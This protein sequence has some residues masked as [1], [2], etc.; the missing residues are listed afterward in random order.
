MA[1]AGA[2]FTGVKATPWGGGDVR[3]LS[4]PSRASQVVFALT[5]LLVLLTLL[6]V[7]AW[8][9]VALLRL[10]TM[11]DGEP[12]TSDALDQRMR[13]LTSGLLSGAIICITYA[14]YEMNWQETCP[15]LKRLAAVIAVVLTAGWAVL[16]MYC[17]TPAL[18]S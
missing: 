13:V 11:G 16:A 6:L 14:I 4:K 9:S 1:L 12:L 17:A 5:P 2:I 18:A 3:Q 7:A 15:Y 10:L 8:A